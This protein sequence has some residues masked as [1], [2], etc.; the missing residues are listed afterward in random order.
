MS[1]DDLASVNLRD[2][3]LR[4]HENMISY[5]NSNIVNLASLEPVYNYFW[6]IP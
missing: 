4:N 2:N 6:D 5:Y 1:K 3:K